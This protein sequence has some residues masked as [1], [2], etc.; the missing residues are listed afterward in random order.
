MVEGPRPV[1]VSNFNIGWLQVEGADESSARLLRQTVYCLHVTN[2]EDEHLQ[3]QF[4]FEV[5]VG[6]YPMS[7]ADLLNLYWVNVEPSSY[8]LFEG[9][10]RFTLVRDHP[11]GATRW[12]GARSLYLTS[13]QSARFVLGTYAEGWRTGHVRLRVPPARRPDRFAI[14]RQT[15]GATARVLLH[16]SHDIDT[17]RADHFGWKWVQ[18]RWFT[19]RSLDYTPADRTSSSVALSTGKAENEIPAED[20]LSVT[21]SEFLEQLNS[22]DLDVLSV[23]GSTDLPDEERGAALL[24]LLAGLDASRKEVDALNR[25]LDQQGSHLRITRKR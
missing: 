8:K 9:Q 19:G 11:S 13:R 23:E 7:K 5:D 20:F 14:G 24:D 10:I 2:L 21:V 1:L 17:F 3:F 12:R 25:F 6:G 18:D 16:A 15:I 22:G 4:E